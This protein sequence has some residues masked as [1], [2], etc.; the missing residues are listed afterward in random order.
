MV[1]V[2]AVLAAFANALS[3]VLQRLGVQGAPRDATMSLGLIRY[4]VRHLVWFAG[5][6]LIAG[7]FLLQAV[8]LRFGRLSQVQPIVTTELLFLVL[9]LGVWF[10]YRLSWR[11]WLGAS[12]AAGGL[13]CFLLVASPGGGT[14]VPSSRNWV[15]VSI[16]ICGL[17]V[18]ASTLGFSGPPWF[19]AGMYGIAGAIVFAF[20]AALT[21]ELT[22]QITHGW[23]H[24]FTT[25]VPYALA[26]SGLVGLFLIQSSFH[27]GPVTASQA[28]LTIVDPL[29]SVFLG[30][31]LFADHLDTSLWRLPVEAMAMGVIVGGIILL[32]RSPLVAASAVAAPGG[33]E[34]AEALARQPK[35]GSAPSV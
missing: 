19:R 29:T 11:E 20:C 2:L 30:I 24:V 32:A 33:E 22:T 34:A 5:V 26:A 1:Y 15:V 7:G 14:N 21:K 4:A 13:A 8:A 27:A 35:L 3:S 23:G 6:A 10:R 17:V 31:W 25:W 12:A 16:V 9:I 28:M 18:T